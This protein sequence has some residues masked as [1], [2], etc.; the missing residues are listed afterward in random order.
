MVNIYRIKYG[1]NI[2]AYYRT[3]RRKYRKKKSYG[4]YLADKLARAKKPSTR[5]YWKMKIKRAVTR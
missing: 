1:D 5:R 2:V 3:K 4:E